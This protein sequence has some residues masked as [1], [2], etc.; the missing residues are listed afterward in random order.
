MIARRLGLAAFIL[1][2]I[3]ALTY[4]MMNLV[5]G[6]AFVGERSLSGRALEDKIADYKARHNFPRY[7]RGILQGDLGTSYP[8][9]ETPVWD[10]I[11]PAVGVSFALGGLAMGLALA[12]GL[13]C[14]VTGA[15]FHNRIPDR[16]AMFLALVGLSV[17]AFVLGPILQLTLGLRFHWVDVAG[18][19]HPFGASSSGSWD[20]MILPA[21]TLSAIPAAT[22]ARLVRSSLLEALQQDYVRTALSK[23]LSRWKAAIRHG[24]RNALLPVVAYLGPAAAGVLMGSIVVEQVFNVPGLGRHFVKGATNRDIEVVLGIVLLDSALLLLFNLLS[25]LAIRKLDP[26]TN[27]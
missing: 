18:W 10:L 3:V 26:R 2:A 6:D 13:A 23:G 21:L 4:G 8:Q 15:F 14:G 22:I 19:W 17:P 5:P 7:V 16:L 12:L 11:G 24:L 27:P 9:G 1:L 25:D 20:L